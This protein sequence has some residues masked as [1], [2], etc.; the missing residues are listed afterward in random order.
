M[1]S[2]RSTAAL[3]LGAATVLALAGCS[4]SGT[5]ASSGPVTVDFWHAMAGPAATE[6]GSLVSEYN[7]HNADHATV[8]ASYQGDYAAV[9][10]KYTA[11]VQSSSTPD[12]LMMNDVSTGFMMDS[13]Q[14]VAPTTLGKV[15]TSSMAPAAERYYSGKDGLAAMPF[16]VSVPVLYL[17]KALVERAGLDPKSP[18]KTLDQVATW[19]EAIHK[20]T[21]AYGFSMNM[22]DSWMLEELSAS[23]G[24]PFCSPDNGRGSTKVDGVSLTSDTQVGFMTRLQ[25]LYQDGVALNP[26]T[27]SAAM[28]SAFASGKVGM[29]MTSS[30]A[31]TTVD[32]D[33]SKSV[34]TTFPT[35]ASSK[36]AGQVIGGNALWISGKG[37]S[38]AEQRASYDFAKWLQTPEV[39]AKWAKAT[40][41]LAMDTGAASTS[42][43]KQSLADPNV[44]AMYRQLA[45]DPSSTAAAGCVTG[46]FPT[47]RATVIGAFNRVVEGAD[48]RATMR[49]AEKQASAQIADYN[50]AAGK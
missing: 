17:D 50:A 40:G 9:Q 28:N 44:A 37:H 48:V 18:P 22:A 47:V 15:D 33:G 1:S 5:A 24:K 23:G 43:G 42:V 29:L 16:S 3:V 21:G 13:G 12:L 14:T 32:P 34:V 35:T 46:A 39:Q 27:D 10:T 8:K 36:D 26:G 2:R 30:G 41:Y 6:L 7:A 31:Y 20:A 45:A 38:T 19:A 49:T 4:A 25:S 11:A